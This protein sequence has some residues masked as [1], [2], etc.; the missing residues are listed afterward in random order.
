MI[1]PTDEQAAALAAFDTGG[2]VVIEAGAGTGKSSVLV[3]MA[4]STPRR[5]QYL[6]FNRSI[7][8]DT[9]ARFGPNV[10]ANTAHSLAFRAVGR[11]YKSRLDSSARMSS[12][13]IARIL[14]IDPF[15]VGR[16]VEH[17]RLAPGFLA[18]HVLRGVE[19]FCQS[20]DP[21]PTG[22]HVPYVDGLDLPQP[23]G[24]KGWANNRELR[25]YLAPF[26]TR[27]WRD[28]CQTKGELPYKHYCYLKSWQLARPIIE[29]DFITIDECFPAGTMVETHLGAVPIEK[30]AE[31]SSEPWSVLSSNDGGKTL[32]WSDVTSA[33]R[34]PRAGSLVRIH[35]D[36]GTLTCTANHPLWV[37]DQGWTPAALVAEG[38]SLRH[39]RGTDDS[40][41][42]ADVRTA[43]R[44]DSRQPQPSAGG[45]G[46]TSPEDFKTHEGGQDRDSESDARPR[47]PRTDGG[48]DAPT[49]APAVSAGRERQGA[50]D[51][52]IGAVRGPD[53]ALRAEALAPR[54]CR[55]EWSRSEGE[56]PAISLQNRRGLPDVA[57]SGGG[58]R[59]VAQ[60]TE[61]TGGRREEGHCPVLSR[62]ARVEVLES[63]GP[64]RCERGGSGRDSRYGAE[65]FTLSVDAGCYFADGVLVKN[66]QDMAPVMR[67]I[68]EAQ[69]GAQLI[70]VGDSQQ[71]LYG[72]TG[73]INALAQVKADSLCYL[74]QSFR[75]GPAVAEVANVVLERLGA[76][77]RLRGLESI[78]STVTTEKLD[79]PAAVLCRTNATTVRKVLTYRQDGKRVHLVG[80]GSEV[81]RFARAAQELQQR[82][83][84]SHPDL[85]CFMDWPSVIDYVS[86]DAMGHELRLLVKLVEEFGVP[87][88]ESALS[89]LSREDAADVVV[90][91]CHKFK[92]RE[93]SSVQ[94]AE[95]FPAADP[96]RDANPEKPEDH[97]AEDRIMYVAV[98]RAQHVLDLSACP[99]LAQEVAS[100]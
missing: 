30:I 92:G 39:L 75:F 60:L 83:S 71:E 86:H 7:V 44:D 26:V 65:V 85:A 12:Q 59:G 29:A 50:D 72:F 2:S 95:D 89:G 62:V 23:D 97:R 21:V 93:A 33:Y 96:E 82:G 77:L 69:T 31:Y 70:W 3:M 81:L 18:G 28:L 48:D 6:A 88:I 58:R 66:C 52:G 17:R 11:Q 80:D 22:E 41:E 91:T 35:H 53:E 20:A 94:L 25:R 32:Q 57:G 1:R 46:G 78:D 61:A 76:P 98:T 9:A 79:A 34:T 64:G 63:G 73:A 51:S 54:V 24:R 43:L 45:G 84:T 4:A 19:R 42:G 47:N 49:W 90:S 38:D 56:G 68:V 5:G 67:A 74:S 16:G 87:V 100:A 55:R 37:E 15:E 36:D 8:R 10:S 40:H 14:R 13:Q 27:A 99:T